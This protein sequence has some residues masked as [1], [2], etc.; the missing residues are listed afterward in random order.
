M[1]RS[2]QIKKLKRI[3]E[4]DIVI[5]GGGA[6][7]LG[8]AVDSTTRGYK[9]LL[10]EA[11]DFAKCTSSRSTKLAHGG[12]R[13]L[14]QGDIAMVYEALNERGLMAKNAA[15]LVRK[16][17]FVIPNYN[18]VDGYY[19]STGLKVYNWMSRSLSLGKTKFLNKEETVERLSTLKQEKLKSGV[20]YFDGQFDDARF[21]INLAQTAVE[22]NAV[23][24][25]YFKAT[26][27]LKKEDGKINGVTIFDQFTQE[28]IKVKS[29]VVVNATGIFIDDILKLDD[30][31][32]EQSIVHSQGVHLVVDSKHLPGKNAL[33]IPKTSDGRVL[34]AVPWHKK[35][36][37]GTT[38]TQVDGAREEPIAL[39]E[40]IEFIIT[41]FNKY[42]NATITRKDVLSVFAGLR[43]L[44]KPKGDKD[45]KEI[46]RSHKIA[47][48]A[49]GLVTISG[50]KWT[51]YRK[52]AEDTIDKII[53]AHKLPDADCITK[54]LSIHG[55]VAKKSLNKKNPLHWYGADLHA[56]ES[57]E[58]QN[59]AYAEKIHPNYPFTMAQVVWAVKQE[60]AETVEDV[61][62]RRTRLLFLD[63]KAAIEAAPAVA[64]CMQTL[65]G[66]DNTW[67][68]AQI[69]AFSKVAKHYLIS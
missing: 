30:K 65:K 14:A 2:S 68:D 47:I 60:F 64:T 54:E 42:I 17:P 9:T 21:A 53:R 46:S 63:A 1:D 16:Q 7:G 26:K 13:Y 41:T 51:T 48:S 35:V 19:Y 5:I 67:K 12:V 28:K 57:L 38:D 69:K 58:N 50:G 27:L 62:A 20:V 52:M 40:E 36:I 33:M 22:N 45:S 24:L 29:K 44:A 4:F 43:P 55:N 18:T 66:K 59:P 10:V 49:S 56:I 6:T 23:L 61:L 8:I 15:H 11:N 25:N 39:E 37:I 3:A 32:S 34:F 31:N